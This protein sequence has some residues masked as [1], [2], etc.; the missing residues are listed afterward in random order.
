MNLLSLLGSYYNLP[1]ESAGLVLQGSEAASD[2]L[3]PKW[4]WER[5]SARE[6][7]NTLDPVINWGTK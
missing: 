2:A 4:F 3:I 1:S 5:Q 6:G 7:Y